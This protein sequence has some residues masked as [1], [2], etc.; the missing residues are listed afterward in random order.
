[1]RSIK[2]S[3]VILLCFVGLLSSCGSKNTDPKEMISGKTSKVWKEDKATSSNGDKD[4]MDKDEKAQRFT[5]YSNGQF[6]VSAPSETAS[7]TWTYDAGGKSLSLQFSGQQV[8]KNFSVDELTE[9][10]MKL[11]VPDGSTLTLENAD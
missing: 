11:R 7:G 6:N 3:V 9:K 10:K 5:F 4:K 2:T 8:T 1:M